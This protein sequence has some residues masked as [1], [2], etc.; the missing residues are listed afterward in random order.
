MLYRRNHPLRQ[1]KM[2]EAKVIIRFFFLS[3][4]EKVTVNL[5]EG[6]EKNEY[7]NT[8]CSS[9]LWGLRGTR[10]V[11]SRKLQTL[12]MLAASPQI[13]DDAGPWTP[14]V[15]LPQRGSTLVLWEWLLVVWLELR[16]GTATPHQH[17]SLWSV[18][19]LPFLQEN[20]GKKSSVL[21][22]A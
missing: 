2:Y 13:P 9:W 21:E 4:Y 20:T 3:F 22:Y 1:K 17:P 8:M 10:T 15:A 5:V 19:S 6:W 14:A 18:L 12:D 11:G 7:Q 16:A